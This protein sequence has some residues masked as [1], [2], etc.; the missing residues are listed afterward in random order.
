MLKMYA[1]QERYLTPKGK[2]LCNQAIEIH[3]LK[4]DKI[5][6][7]EPRRGS[8]KL[9]E[10][11]FSQYHISTRINYLMVLYIIYIFIV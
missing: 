3:Q 11:K 6:K 9:F 8:D 7:G 1:I 10:V 5:Q 2:N 4:Y